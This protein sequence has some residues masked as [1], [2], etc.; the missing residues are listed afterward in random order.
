MLVIGANYDAAP[1]DPPAV[2]APFGSGCMELA[3]L[4]ADL[5]APQAV[6]GSTDVAMRQFLPP[7]VLAFTVTNPMYER[8]CALDE[9]SFLEKPFTLRAPAQSIK[10]A[11]D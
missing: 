6:I 10:A 2:I 9:R 11:L 8:L 4:F 3:P 7:D 5:D 1:G